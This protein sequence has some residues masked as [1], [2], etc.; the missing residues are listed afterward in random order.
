MSKISEEEC[1]SLFLTSRYEQRRVYPIDVLERKCIFV[2]AVNIRF[3]YINWASRR[4]S[5][6]RGVTRFA[7]FFLFFFINRVENLMRLVEAASKKVRGEGNKTAICA[8]RLKPWSRNWVSTAICSISPA[9]SPIL[10]RKS[11]FVTADWARLDS[12]GWNESEMNKGW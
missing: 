11:I 1:K 8:C 6:Q 5:A 3:D 12:R 4:E 9:L 10:A 7:C 2:S